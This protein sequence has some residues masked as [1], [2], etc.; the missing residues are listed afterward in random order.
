MSAIRPL[1]LAA[2]DEADLSVLSAHV[3]DAVVKVADIKWTAASG[4][5]IVPMNRFSWETVRGRR[6]ASDQRRRAVLHFDRVRRVQSVGVSARDRDAVLSILAVLF[7]E[8]EAPAG[9]VS[10][11]CSGDSVLKLDVECVEARLTDLGA[12]WS[13]SMRPKHAVG[14]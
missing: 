4:Q 13:A 14:R 7:H 8:A 9:T 1:K 3:Q 10:I 5:L 2:L 11:V 12:A 6:R